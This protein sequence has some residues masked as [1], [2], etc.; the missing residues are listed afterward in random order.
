MWHV[1][2]G[3]AASSQSLNLT[4]LIEN[5]CLKK[6]T[7]VENTQFKYFRNRVE[8]ATAALAK[9]SCTQLKNTSL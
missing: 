2:R 9:N 1:F 6:N 7:I 8:E 4:T 5:K 3:K